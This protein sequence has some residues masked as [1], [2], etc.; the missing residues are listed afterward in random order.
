MSVL[1][2][3]RRPEVD[4]RL[5]WFPLLIIPLLIILS[6]RLWYVQIIEA[7]VLVEAA[8][9]SGK[10]IVPKLAPRGTIY[11]RKGN[12][13]AGVEGRIVVTVKPSEAKKN[14]ETV[15]KLAE[16]LQI[17]KEDILDRIKKE[18]WRNRPAP[19]KVG[20]SVEIA[21]QIAESADLPGV[22]IDEIPMRKYHDTKNFSHL[23]GYVW[24][25]NDGD[26]RMLKA[27]GIEAADYVGKDGLEK[28][29][30]RDL[31][32][33][34]GKDITEGS[35]K[36][37]FETEEPAIEGK[38][39]I[40][41]L[42]ASL[43]EFA[44]KRLAST[45]YKGAIVAIDPRNGEILALV[46]N[47]SYDTS[48]YDGGI[49]TDDYRK[50][51]DNPQ[52]PAINRTVSEQYAP[53]STFKLLTSIGAYRAGVL[54]SS[55]TEFCDGSYHYSSKARMK[56]LGTHGT[57]GYTEALTR[58]CNAYFATLAA[59]AGREE[60]MR[61][62][63]D[64]GFGEKTGIDLFGEVPGIIPTESW[65]T[66]HKQTFQPGNLA[67]MGVGQGFTAVTPL[68]MANLAALV[69]NRGVQ[70][71]PHSLHAMRDPLTQKNIYIQPEVI[72]TVK[73]DD[74]FWDMMQNALC[75]VIENGTAKTAKIAGMR[76]GGKTGSA[77]HGASIEGRTHG[78]FVGFAPRDNPRIAICVLAEGV[79]HGGDHAAP[80]AGDV[81][82]HYLFKPAKAPAN[83][84]ASTDKSK[85][86]FRG[87]NR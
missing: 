59:K 45:G 8:S 71:R 24:T 64:C 33:T 9:K 7:P 67:Q 78:W 74:W 5:Y 22:E 18:E 65:L 76:W 26:E 12:I 13:I 29:Y 30:E 58:S 39:L 73:A 3:P 34:P 81:V 15:D 61:A 11:D 41:S 1:H 57:I 79:G 44:Q 6:L 28:F 10:S 72:H 43:Q 68:Q 86:R 32:G 23:L 51:M 87:T 4:R 48:I 85:P 49:S 53:G 14:P 77:E 20:I 55:T 38:K 25:P 54:T 27:K 42:D 19:I 21:T 75:N 31:M 62:A 47:P 36:A 17:P 46:S 52:N 70:Y 80:I 83:L 63:I 50:L 35:K 56:C 66:K 40:L 37:K 16:L 69:A 84:V 2:A 82:R 60:M